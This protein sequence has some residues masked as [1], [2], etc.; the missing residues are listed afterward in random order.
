MLRKNLKRILLPG[1]L[2]FLIILFPGIAI[3]ENSD[4]PIQYYLKLASV[5]N[6]DIIS[7]QCKVN[8]T[9]DVLRQNYTNYNLQ[10]TNTT[11]DS[12]SASSGVGQTDLYSSQ[13]NASLLLF[14]SGK[15][16]YA[17]ESARQTYYQNNFNLYTTQQ[18]VYITIISSYYDFLKNKK[19]VEVSAENVK[20]LEKKLDQ[21][22]EFFKNG[23]RPKI[24]VTTASVELYNEKITSL[25]FRNQ[26]LTA[27]EQLR[28]S[29]GTTDNMPKPKMISAVTDYKITLSDALNC[30][31]NER[32]DLKSAIAN[33]QSAYFLIKQ[34]RVANSPVINLISNYNW[35][36]VNTNP[37]PNSS[38]IGI[39]MTWNIFNGGLTDWQV[40]QLVENY[41]DLS[42]QVVNTRLQIQKDVSDAYY[43]MDKNYETLGLYDA[44]L[45]QATENLD[46]ANQRY[47]LGVGDITELTNAQTAFFRS[48]AEKINSLYEFLKSKAQ[49]EKT[50]G[51]DLFMLYSTGGK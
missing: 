31:Y 49:L 22:T 5:N 20:Y 46:L 35:Q 23:I 1:L 44:K 17:I 33:A 37:L 7:Y 2:I 21:I 29:A 30:A 26:S 40:N 32:R 41:K 38:Q 15:T 50:M 14:D 36:G 34:T 13:L 9:Y 11:T 51:L 8:A 12:K 3:A 48:Q 16:H 47:T 27:Y 42:S 10:I 6:P 43:T 19:L 45:D 39:Q 18:N 4:Q 28:K 24:D 25:D